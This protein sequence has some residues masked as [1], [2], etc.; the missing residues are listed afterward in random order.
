MPNRSF[1]LMTFSIRKPYQ[2]ALRLVREALAENG[3][4][5]AAELDVTSRIKQELG[6]GIAPCTVF[7]VDDPTLLLEGI[8]FHRGAPLWI[9][10]RVA[11]SGN[12]RH[13][14]VFVRS[15]NSNSLVA[16]GLPVSLL[17]PILQLQERIVHTLESIAERESVVNA[18]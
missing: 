16:G 8:V 10:Q 11:M 7:F 4:L 9:P 14:E 3:L 12:E 6:A 18:L 5:V 13:T 15:A 17:D 1:P 2:T